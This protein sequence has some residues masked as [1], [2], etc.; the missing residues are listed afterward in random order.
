MNTRAS[1]PRIFLVTPLDAEPTQ[2][3][4]GASIVAADSL[5]TLQKAQEIKNQVS[6]YLQNRQASIG[7]LRRLLNQLIASD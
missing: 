7:T 3:P 6:S 4:E 2:V 1:S 5:E